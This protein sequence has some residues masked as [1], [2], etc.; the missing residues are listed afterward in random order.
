MKVL[1]LILFFLGRALTVLV[2]AIP[3]TYLC[4]TASLGAL[5]G[6]ATMLGGEPA[7]FLFLLWA[8]AG[9]YGT[10]SLWAVGFG[11]VRGWSIAGLVVGTIALL[12]IAGLFLTDETSEGLHEDPEGILFLSPIVVALSW[13]VVLIARGVLQPTSSGGPASEA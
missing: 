6:F 11:F 12:P 5:I 4:V 1:K 9:F 13:L 10:L 8:L 3:A 7:G 2:G